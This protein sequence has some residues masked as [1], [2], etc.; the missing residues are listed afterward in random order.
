MQKTKDFSVP[1]GDKPLGWHQLAA[2]FT[3]SAR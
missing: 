3:G 2:P 1:V